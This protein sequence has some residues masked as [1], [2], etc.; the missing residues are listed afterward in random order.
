LDLRYAPEAVDVRLV[1]T[2]L[3]REQKLLVCPLDQLKVHA[4]VTHAD[5]D[6]LLEEY[7]EAAYDYL[8][9]PDGWLG[10]ACLLEEDWEVYAPSRLG[11]LFELPLRPFVG[12]SL[13][14]FDYLQA[15]GTYA[16]V[17][18]SRFV[19]E[20]A[21]IFARVSLA[22]GQTWPY[23]GTFH[24]RAYRIRF[25]AGFAPVAEPDRVPSPIRLAMKMLAASWYAD[26][27]MVGRVDDRVNH[28][29]VKLAGRYRVEP[30]HS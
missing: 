5:E 11:R 15:D 18:A 13:T 27:E 19:L 29:L 9:G 21:Q 23:T 24:P 17:D 3:T 22:Y 20:P 25:T 12:V 16:P 28:G 26:R 2:P 14:S 1:S 8:S 7:I 4:K 30:D 10:G 6:S